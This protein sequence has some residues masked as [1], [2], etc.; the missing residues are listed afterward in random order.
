[1]MKKLKF[2]P[3][4]F[5]NGELVLI[6]QRKLPNQ[7][8]LVRCASVRDAWLAIR[9]M[10][11]RGAPAIGVAA[12]YGVCLDVLRVR[13]KSR[14]EFLSMLRKSCDLL[15][16]ARPTAVNLAWAVERIW[17]AANRS[18]FN[19]AADLK[20]LILNEAVRIHRE[21]IELCFRI[22]NSGKSLIQKSDTVLTYCNAGGLATTGYGTALAPI[23]DAKKQGKRFHVFSCETR[24]QLQ[25]ARLTMWELQKYK[26][27]ST[28]ICDSM[29]GTLMQKGKISLVITGAD[30]IVSN[31][32]TA[33][34]IG[35]Y[36]VACLAKLHGV[37]FYVAAPSSTFDFAKKTGREIPIE[38][39]ASHEITRIR[40]FQL[41]PKGVNAFNPAF[42]VTPHQLIAGFITEKGILRAPY[43]KSLQC[44]R[45]R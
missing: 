44:L 42:D 11:V 41:A 8:K 3:V 27:P 20:K 4:L 6:D 18:K 34:K 38:E 37:P 26:V 17:N 35:T 22:G 33:N 10:V 19:S 29:V 30:R 32:D 9:D 45:A 28:L 13:L 16:T 7:M 43:G 12:G 23:F 21:D 40:G 36:Q 31:G 15:K 2:E 25:G 5:R 1:M 39:R 24:P 14:A